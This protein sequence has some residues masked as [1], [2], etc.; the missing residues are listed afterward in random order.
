MEAVLFDLD[1]TLIS[2]KE[3]A[4]SGYHAVA[5]VLSAKTGESE[6]AVFESLWALFNE[7]ARLVF[8]RFLEAR[9]IF[10][11]RE[12]I[13]SLIQV[14]R[15][16]KP[17]I[18]FHGDVAETIEG[19][20]RK[21]CFLGIISDGFAVAQQNKIDALHAH[22]YFDKI[23]LTDT[24]GKEYWKPSPRAFEMM[25]QASRIPFEKTIYVGDN[26]EKDFY[27][28]ALLPVKTARIRREDGV[29][30]DAEYRENIR[31]TYMLSDLRE[32]LEL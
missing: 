1:D 16:H 9:R 28:S 29:Y 5:K 26:P 2:E 18:S 20:R 12:E 8:N 21:G 23:I 3:Y 31:E 17:A 6:D 27:I 4:K 22:D 24:L 25:Q 10:F 11:T 30:R 13:L 15:E 19:L 32:L 14:Y 7:D